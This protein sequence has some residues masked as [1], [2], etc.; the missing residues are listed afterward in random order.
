[1]SKQPGPESPV[2]A[3]VL[4]RLI[5]AYNPGVTLLV[6]VW[7]IAHSVRRYLMEREALSRTGYEALTSLI[8]V[9]PVMLVGWALLTASKRFLGLSVFGRDDD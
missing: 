3:N 8:Y 4:G 6:L 2:P 9:V 1:M 7:V 5:D